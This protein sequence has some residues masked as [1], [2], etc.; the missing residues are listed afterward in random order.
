[1]LP[2]L[3][4]SPG[5]FLCADVLPGRASR[6]ADHRHGA[7]GCTLNPRRQQSEMAPPK[8]QALAPGSLESAPPSL[9]NKVGLT[10]VPCYSDELR[11]LGQSDTTAPIVKTGASRRTTNRHSV[12][13]QA[14]T[15]HAAVLYGCFSVEGVGAK[16]RRSSWA[17]TGSNAR[18]SSADG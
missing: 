14:V 8:R 7:C 3:N 18:R 12:P 13:K 2:A 15:N 10:L 9:H 16:C 4:V 6:A 5:P 1:M 11:W 17:V